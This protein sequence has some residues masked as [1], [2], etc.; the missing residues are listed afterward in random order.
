VTTAAVRRPVITRLVLRLV[1]L[2]AA[3]GRVEGVV[4][5]HTR[6]VR[7]AAALCVVAA[8]GIGGN[9]VASTVLPVASG[10]VAVDGVGVVVVAG[11]VILVRMV[12][13]VPAAAAGTV[14]SGVPE[15]RL[16]REQV[17]VGLL[18]AIP[19]RPELPF[20]FVLVRIAV[21]VRPIRRLLASLPPHRRSIA[22]HVV[23]LRR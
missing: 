12:A 1:R 18:L 17:H 22:G 10:R 23:R 4:R 14:V 9:R 3:P 2:E 20:V 15:G 16:G 6:R 7:V 21:V 5:V 11:C 8:R 13:A 19:T